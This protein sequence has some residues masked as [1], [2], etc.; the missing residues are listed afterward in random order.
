MP[1][2][3]CWRKK[4]KRAKVNTNQPK[5]EP[6]MATEVWCGGDDDD[7]DDDDDDE[8]GCGDD[9]DDDDDDDD[10]IQSCALDKMALSAACTIVM[11]P[12]LYT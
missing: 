11:M 6:K 12:H 3:P 4:G 1:K 2:G 9:D 5:L 10:H 7:D 8:G